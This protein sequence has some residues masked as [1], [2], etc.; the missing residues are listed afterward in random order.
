MKTTKTV[1]AVL[2]LMVTTGLLVSCTDTEL[3]DGTETAITI[4]NSILYGTAQGDSE[5]S[6]GTEPVPPSNDEN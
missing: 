6:G 4:E 2:M 3:D 1:F 5:N